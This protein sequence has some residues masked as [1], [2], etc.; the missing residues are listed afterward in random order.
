MHMHGTRRLGTSKRTNVSHWYWK[1]RGELYACMYVPHVF[2]TMRRCT[3]SAR[4]LLMLEASA[5]ARAANVAFSCFAGLRVVY[6]FILGS[7]CRY[8]EWKRRLHV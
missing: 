4:T 3:A 2:L 6:M 5:L 1:R 8:R 7:L